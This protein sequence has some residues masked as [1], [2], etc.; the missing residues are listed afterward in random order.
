MQ[1]A[2]RYFFY[3][4]AAGDTRGE[5]ETQKRARTASRIAFYVFQIAAG[6][7][8]QPVILRNIT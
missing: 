5:R 6:S 8:P 3:K 4:G 2:S 1:Q 7:V